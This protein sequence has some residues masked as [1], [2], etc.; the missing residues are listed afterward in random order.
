M[1][2]FRSKTRKSPI[3]LFIL[4]GIFLLILGCVSV[5]QD[6]D[7]DLA[8]THSVVGVVVDRRDI[9]IKDGKRHY[10]YLYFLLNNS[11]QQFV[12]KPLPSHPRDLETEVIIGNTVKVFFRP[13][14]GYNKNV[15][16]IE[17]NGKILADYHTYNKKESSTT[18]IFLFA[19]VFLIISAILLHRKIS[20]WQVLNRLVR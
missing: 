12:I 2:I 10:R 19:G 18:A 4:L 3:L 13:A 11:D 6:I 8:K 7:L 17:K 16:Q 9:Y 20:I 15:Y 1:P 14:S 5:I